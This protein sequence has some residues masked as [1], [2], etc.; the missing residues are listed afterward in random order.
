VIYIEDTTLRRTHSNNS[1][2]RMTN[3]FVV[4]AIF[5]VT[6][7]F[8]ALSGQAFAQ[9][10]SL[11]QLLG[12]GGGGAGSNG[13][14]GGGSSGGGGGLSQLFGGGGG[15]S[16]GAR[17]QRS[18]GSAISIERSAPP[19][20][21]K[22]SGKQNTQ[23]VQSTITA[24]FACYPAHDADIPQSNAFI[25]Y[26]GN[27]NSGGPPSGPPPDGAAYGPPSGGQGY[28]PAANGSPPNGSPPGIE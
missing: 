23:G 10:F 4:A 14:G 12:G 26:I 9:G 3:R 7:F 17:P 11:G 24:Q 27:S 18:D 21:G 25:C 5:V 2:Y 19:Y 8:L 28:G 16:G 20:T 22:F 15:G 13:G 6:T 1:N